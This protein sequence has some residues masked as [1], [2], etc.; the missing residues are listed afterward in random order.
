MLR[1]ILGDE[2]FFGGLLAYREAFAYQSAT[3]EDFKA[4]LERESGR[5]LGWFF[6]RWVYG[7]G[8]PDYEYCWS[9]PEA[10]GPATLAIEQTQHTE[11]F[12][13]PIEIDVL[14]EKGR[15]RF[16]VW[17][18]LPVQI[19]RLDVSAPVIDLSFDPDSWILAFHDEVPFGTIEAPGTDPGATEGSH[20]P[21]RDKEALTSSP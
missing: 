17:D 5:E 19:F 21:T 20:I 1:G 16:T 10:D 7:E 2:A 13:M 18:S 14:M 8:R 3:T 12:T 6:D 11:T 4:V 9:Q 15:E